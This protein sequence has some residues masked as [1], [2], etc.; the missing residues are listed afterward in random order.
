MF[1]QVGNVRWPSSAID[2][3]QG[4][5]DDRLALVEQL[6]NAALQWRRRRR[7]RSRFYQALR[8]HESG[9]DQSAKHNHRGERMMELPVFGR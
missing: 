5:I 9:H 3:V 7:I 1:E 6:P 4:A 2:E 8:L